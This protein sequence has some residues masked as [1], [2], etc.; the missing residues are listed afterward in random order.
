MLRATVAKTLS[1]K[2]DG[3]N[4]EGIV[5]VR[6][7]NIALYMGV[8]KLNARHLRQMPKLRAV[9]FKGKLLWN[10]L[11]LATLLLFRWCRYDSQHDRF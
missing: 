7:K 2:I 3:A 5:C 6:L 10:T 11:H 9:F 8:I 4:G 1:A